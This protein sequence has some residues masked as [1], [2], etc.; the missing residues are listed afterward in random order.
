MASVSEA[1]ND[2]FDTILSLEDKFYED[3]FQLGYK[4][5]ER[6]GLVEGRCFGLEKGFEKFLLMGK[7]HGNAAVW[8]ARLKTQE[9]I[10]ESGEDAVD[11]VNVTSHK[12]PVPNPSVAQN[13]RLA[14]HLK[15]LYALTEMETLSTQNTE[16]AIAEFDDRL[17]RAEGKAKII[18]KLTG[19]RRI[20]FNTKG[21]LTTV[22]SN[23]ETNLEGNIEDTS[24]L[25][26][27]H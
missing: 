8:S 2:P 21:S 27:R 24:I 4:D 9:D 15:T 12:F 1:E 19:D 16:D 3:G 17:R 23:G 20:D 13:L 22:R 26:A 14:S 18:E 11:Q 7:L 25:N 6:V 10:V 5:G